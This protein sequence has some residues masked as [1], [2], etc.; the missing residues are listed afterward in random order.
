MYELVFDTK[1]VAFLENVEQ[2]MKKRI[3]R[4]I[5]ADKTIQKERCHKPVS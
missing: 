5:V 4:K 1:A 3:F 2:K